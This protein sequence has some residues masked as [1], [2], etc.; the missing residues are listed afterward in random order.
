MKL[1]LQTDY[2]L[3]VLLHA[4]AHPGAR[5]AIADVAAVHDVSRNHLMKVVN[6][7]ATMGLIVTARGRGGGFWLARDPASITVGEVVRA[8]EPTLQPADCGNCVLYRGCGLKPV[9]GEA[10]SAFLG[11]LDSKSLA[12]AVAHGPGAPLPAET[13]MAAPVGRPSSLSETVDGA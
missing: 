6:Q 12:D 8:F 4:A 2:A 7:L 5:L 10:M 1:T 3:R 13:K 11:V 9:L